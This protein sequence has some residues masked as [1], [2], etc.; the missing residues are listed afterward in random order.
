LE[1]RS[2][3]KAF[4]KQWGFLLLDKL[5]YLMENKICLHKSL[6]IDLDILCVKT[7]QEGH[8]SVGRVS[9]FPVSPKQN[10]TKQNKTKKTAEK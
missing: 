7:C 6:N 8:S 5:E 1:Q 4:L 9:T 2:S 10:K 3:S